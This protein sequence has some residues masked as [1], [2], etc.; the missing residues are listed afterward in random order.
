M[1]KLYDKKDREIK[2]FDLIKVYHFTDRR[3][4]KR[5]M[6]KWVKRATA[7]KLEGWAA[8]HLSHDNGFFWLAAIAENNGVLPDVEIIQRGCKDQ[9]EDDRNI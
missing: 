7:G 3:N 8:F 6:Y 9:T 2:E 4:R 1:K 5:Y